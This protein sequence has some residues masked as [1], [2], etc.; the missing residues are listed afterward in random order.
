M[1]F[2]LVHQGVLGYL[3]LVFNFFSLEVFYLGLDDLI[4][5]TLTYW[6]H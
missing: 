3:L 5:G 6:L 1:V 2:K 4:P